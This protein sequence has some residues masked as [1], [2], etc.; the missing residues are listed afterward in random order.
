MAASLD[1]LDPLSRPPGGRACSLAPWLSW[2]K[3][4][5]SKQE[6]L[7]SNPSGAFGRAPQY[8]RASAFS[9]TD[10]EWGLGAA[11]SWVRIPAVPL[12]EHW[13]LLGERGFSFREQNANGGAVGR[14][15][16]EPALSGC[17]RKLTRHSDGAPWLSWSKRLSCKQEILGSNP[18][19]ASQAAALRFASPL[20]MG[21]R[22]CFSNH[23][24]T[25]Q[26]PEGL[27]FLP[28]QH[29]SSWRWRATKP[30]DQPSRGSARRP[31]GLCGAMDSA[32]DF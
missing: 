12:G 25:A 15:A 5:S 10:G 1:D 11:R 24:S 29:A 16:C 4:L 3:R 28:K 20:D 9:K 7:G 8:G 23:T 30:E 31:V 13:H 17:R 26:R 32:L 21:P 18:S 6:I 22:Q 19:G 2:L 27:S 14:L